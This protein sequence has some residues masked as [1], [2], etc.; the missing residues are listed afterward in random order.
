[1]KGCGVRV[2]NPDDLR[3]EVLLLCSAKILTIEAEY[4]CRHN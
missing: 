3:K 1:M 2:I 4:R